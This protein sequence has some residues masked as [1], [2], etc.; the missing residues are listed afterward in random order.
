VD[1]D[2]IRAEI[3]GGRPLILGIT[4]F[5]RFFFPGAGGRIDAPD[6]SATARGR[7]A[8]LAA[9]YDVGAVLIRNSWSSDWGLDGYGW[10][11]ND[12]ITAHVREVW[13]IGPGLTELSSSVTAGDTYGA[14]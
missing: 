11:S 10:L 4:V 13:A 8:V 6:G 14:Q 9:G 3:D 7:H 12:Y 5:D 1:L 2:V